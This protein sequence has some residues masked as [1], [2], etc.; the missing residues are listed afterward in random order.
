[1]SVLNS[2]GGF[3]PDCI[4]ARMSA[5][6]STAFGKQ[7]IASAADRRALSASDSSIRSLGLRRQAALFRAIDGFPSFYRG[8]LVPSR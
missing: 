6:T 2:S 7:N 3:D 4:D 5:P 8:S 1:M